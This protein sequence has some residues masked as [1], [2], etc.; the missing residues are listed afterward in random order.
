MNTAE[1]EREFSAVGRMHHLYSHVAMTCDVENENHADTDR[2]R[3]QV[4][5]SDQNPAHSLDL[6]GTCLH[7]S[8]RSTFWSQPFFFLCFPS[9]GYVV[10]SIVMLL[11][12]PIKHTRS[13]QMHEG[14]LEH[15]LTRNTRRIEHKDH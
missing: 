15:R 3:M 12:D 5:G 13:A 2:T 11:T 9:R 6:S 4:R 7:C 14:V 1:W 10:R 8:A